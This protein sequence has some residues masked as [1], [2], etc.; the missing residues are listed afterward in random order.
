VDEL[1]MQISDQP[2][3]DIGAALNPMRA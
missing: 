3:I 2:G 1:L